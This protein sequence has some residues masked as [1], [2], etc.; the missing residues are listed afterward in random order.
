MGGKDDGDGLG[1]SSP[2]P[3]QTV[4]E[5]V[6]HGARRAALRN[7]LREASEILDQHDPQRD[8]HRPEFAD[9]ERLHLLIGPDIADQHLGV[10]AAVGMGDEGPGHA[11]D[12]GIAGEGTRG[13]LGKLAVIAG[14]QVRAKLP[15]LLLDEMI[16][17]DEP[18]RRRRYGATLVDR[19][20]DGAIS[21]EQ[22][23]AIVGKPPRQRL[24]L[25]RPGRYDLRERKAS[26]MLLEALDAE[27][28][29]ANGL[30]VVPERRP[31]HAFKGAACERFQF[32]LSVAR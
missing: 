12:A 30:L 3:E 5:A 27:Q 32:D 29:F 8:R 20:D 22:N 28:L 4:G 1:G 17:V 21:L 2:G 24:T 6:R 14:R 15:N 25:G 23:G 16:I 11:E 10:E 31:P 13:E 19:L 7:L 18:F 9:G 26:R